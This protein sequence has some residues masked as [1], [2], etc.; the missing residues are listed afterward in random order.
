MKNGIQ[1]DMHQILEIFII[2]A[3]DRIDCLLRI[4]HCIQK[5]VQG[6]L[7][8]FH[9]RIFDRIFVRTTQNSVLNDMC[10]PR[11]ILRRCAKTD[12]K[13]LIVIIVGNHCDPRSAFFVAENDSF[14]I[15]IFDRAFF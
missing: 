5:G 7:H 9:K 12:I 4:S 10:H 11:G 6:T 14:G 15:E 13:D 8:Q 3:C 1:I 2:A